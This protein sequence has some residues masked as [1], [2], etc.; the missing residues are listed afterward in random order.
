MRTCTRQL[1][2]IAATLLAGSLA[3]PA[4]AQ[5]PDAR[6]YLDAAR[7]FADTVLEH[8]RDT[9][10]NPA[11][12]LFVD[13]LHS[14]SMAP[15]IWKWR[16]GEEWVLSNFANQQALM[17]LLDGLTALTGQPKYREAAEAA[18]RH[19]LEH[20]TA[21]PNGLPYW[22]GHT[23]VDLKTGRPVGTQ[24][25]KAAESGRESPAMMHELKANQPYWELMW[26][27]NPERTRRVMTGLW[28]GHITNWE[29]LDFNRHFLM[30]R[31]T[32]PQWNAAFDATGE[33]PFQTSGGLSFVSVVNPFIYSAAVIYANDKL[34]PALTWA[35]RMV[36][37][38]QRARHPKTGLSG[39]QLSYYPP[40]KDRFISAMGHLYPGYNEAQLAASYHQGGRYH[41]LPLAQMHAAQVLISAGGKAAETGRQWIKWA[42]EDLKT[43][44]MLYDREKGIFKSALTDGTFIDIA[45]I[46]PGY[47]TEDDLLPIPP[48]GKL[49]WGNAMAYSL[50]KDNAHA[51]ILR[52]IGRELGLGDVG[53][54]RNPGKTDSRDFNT[55]YGLLELY[56]ATKSPQFLRLAA[57][58]GDNLIATQRPN[59]LFPRPAA[60][61]RK[62]GTAPSH[63]AI[64]GVAQPARVHARTGDDYPL[65]LLHLAATIAGQSEKLSRAVQDEQYFHCPY[66]GPLQRF[67]TKR[68]D[69]RT[70]DWLV[71]Y[72]VDGSW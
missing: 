46:K 42:S 13:G 48:G 47:Y 7:R 6:R 55:L 34:E 64:P 24:A 49:F 52:T 15:A 67:Q 25:D 63:A 2:M 31:R 65:A 66:R 45:G 4:S 8:G 27:V 44:M 38:W 61:P 16:D 37:Q 22:G 3:G 20:Q 33:I 57:A 10:G 29:R 12:P 36:G 14:E 60:T 39:G 50:T 5:E 19:M 35:E 43:Y 69:V 53:D 21:A 18:T 41:S 32:T 56:R 51:E 23:A 70:Y 71:F 72:G 17:R 40:D 30:H 68:D 54:L 1:R 26:R 11:T 28:A 58:I 59:G 62:P 9:Y